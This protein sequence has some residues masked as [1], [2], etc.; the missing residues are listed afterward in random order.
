MPE[1]AVGRGLRTSFCLCFPSQRSTA[2]QKKTRVPL[3]REFF[4]IYTVHFTLPL[5]WKK[6][7]GIFSS[8]KSFPSKPLCYQ[9]GSRK[10]LTEKRNGQWGWKM[11]GTA[12]HMGVIQTPILVCTLTLDDF[13]IVLGGGMFLAWQLGSQCAFFFDILPGNWFIYSVCTC[14]LHNTFCWV[15]PGI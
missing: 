11:S 6:H 5:I 10:N 1:L 7:N 13:I 8:L 4:I 2:S 9:S 15:T 3:L 14:K 12:V